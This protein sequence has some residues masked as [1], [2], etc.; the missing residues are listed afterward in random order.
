[1]QLPTF[2]ADGFVPMG[3]LGNDYY[4]YD[5]TGHMIVGQRT[6]LGYRL[7]DAVEVR[8]VEAIPLAGSM[9]FQ[10]LSE[11]RK[12]PGSTASHHKARG[13][14]KRPGG[15]SGPPHGRRRRG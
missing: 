4:H 2:G 5:E 3:S 13:R 1:M 15:R 6:Q 8:L 11:P 10:M 7:G 12:L 14:M 9:R